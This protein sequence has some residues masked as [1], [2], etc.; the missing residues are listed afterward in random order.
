MVNL[1]KNSIESK[2]MS[3][4]RFPLAAFVVFIHTDYSTDGSNLAYYIGTLLSN[5]IAQVAVPTFFFISGYLFFAKIDRFG[6]KEYVHIM[7]RKFMALA[8]PYLLWIALA[9]YGYSALRGF[10]DIQPWDVYKIFWAQSDGYV[11]TSVFGYK[12]SI[13]SSPSG[14]GVLWF[15]RDLMVA[16][17]MSPIV[18]VIVRRLKLY[19]IIVFILPYLLYLGIPVRGFGLVALCF[20][21]LGAT[22][23][24][25]GYRVTYVLSR[26]G[27]IIISCFLILVILKFVLDVNSITYHRL[28]VQGLIMFGVAA[29]LVIA[30]VCVISGS[31]LWLIPLGET[32][33]FVYVFHALPI[34]YPAEHMIDKIAYWSQYGPTIAYFTNWVGRIIVCVVIFYV[35]KLCMPNL[36]S[37]LTGG[38]LKK[39]T[40]ESLVTNASKV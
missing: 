38:R 40:H 24:I 31:V 28:L 14:C 10:G 15:V 25:L 5:G 32:S 19:A 23:S 37:M 13:L 20:F 17:V 30:R 1:D 35:L 34:F 18:W 29:C 26:F 8:V 3:W 27:R 16:M 39:S 7:K 9:F 6:I 36:L 2:A 22:F 11:V 21:P 33:F 4:L 12:F